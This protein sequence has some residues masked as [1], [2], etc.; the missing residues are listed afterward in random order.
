MENTAADTFVMFGPTAA[1]MKAFNKQSTNLTQLHK[2]K[3]EENG[4]IQT[5]HSSN[6]NITSTQKFLR[7][8]L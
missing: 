2:I 6:K 1:K 8:E 5:I 7:Y 3:G 4:H